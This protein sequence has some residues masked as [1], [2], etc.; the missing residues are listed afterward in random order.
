MAQP[1]QMQQYRQS[2]APMAMSPASDFIQNLFSR[3]DIQKRVGQA[4]MGVID[5]PA[6]AEQCIITAQDP[7]FAG[8]S[9]ESLLR[10]MLQC[11]QMGL[12]PGKAHGL[13]ALI[14]RGGEVNVQPQWQGFKVLMERMPNVIEVRPYL[15]HRN[16][17]F[18]L[19]DGVPRHKWNP[20]DDNRVFRHPSDL[21]KDE[22]PDL[23]GGYL[24][25]D[26]VDGRKKYHFISRAKIEKRRMCSE[27]PDLTRK[28]KPGVW[29][30]WYEE[31]A[32]K[33]VIR[34]AWAR[35]A[36][37]YDPCAAPAVGHHLT[38]MTEADDGELQTMQVPGMPAP[39]ARPALAPPPQTGSIPTPASVGATSH[40]TI[41]LPPSTDPETGEVTEP[42]QAG[43]EV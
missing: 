43:L 39:V 36:V 31:M 20:L 18:E 7:S 1:N 14:P 3:D 26:L 5:G 34:D 10:A 13:V 42:A 24:V 27:V 35:R 21:K 8:C 12:T 11:A 41:D 2:A 4:L 15:V 23:M 16:D 38:A 40:A 17:E 28:G 9:P 25:I 32:T 30:S 37:P 19:V 6:F 22:P 29:R 33:T